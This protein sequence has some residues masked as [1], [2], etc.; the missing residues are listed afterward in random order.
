MKIE[1]KNSLLILFVSSI[2]LVMPALAQDPEIQRSREVRLEKVQREQ[3]AIE[4][5][6]NS[7]SASRA[8]HDRVSTSA[9]SQEQTDAIV[10]AG[11]TGDKA[12]IPY[13]KALVAA[14]DSRSYEVE[15]ALVHL[16]NNEYFSKTVVEL[17]SEDPGVRYY[18]IGKLSRFKTKEAYRKLYELLD[19]DTD[20][21]DNPKD[22]AIIR[23]NAEVVKD[24]LAS[25][26][27]NP[28]TASDQCKTAKWKEWFEKNKHLIE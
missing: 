28:P 6:A 15:I 4:K 9:T 17:S 24:W 1:V 7:S 23:T 2:G 13:L 10:E 19:D 26:V 25:T 14:N 20:R 18:A 12:V 16:G 27:E 5:A 11:R 21:D 8:L 3:I 22:D